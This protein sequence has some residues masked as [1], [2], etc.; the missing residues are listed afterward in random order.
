MKKSLLRV[1]LGFV[2]SAGAQEVVGNVIKSTTPSDLNKYKKGLVVVGTF[3]ISGMIGDAA[4]R[5]VDR[6]IEDLKEVFQE[7][8]D[9]QEEGADDDTEES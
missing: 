9:M 8:K 7:A 5:Y 1:G 4:V 6:Q 3:V 2:A